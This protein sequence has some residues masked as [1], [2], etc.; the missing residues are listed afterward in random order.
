[1]AT[2]AAAVAHD[3]GGPPV[4]AGFRLAEGRTVLMAM[5]ETTVH[6]DDGA[7]PREDDVRTAGEQSVFRA[8]HR[9]AVTETVEHRSENELG[10][11][12]APADAGHDLRALFRGEDVGH[13]KKV[14]SVQ[15]SVFSKSWKRAGEAASRMGSGFS[16]ALPGDRERFEHR[17]S[18]L[19]HRT[20]KWMNECRERDARAPSGLRL[21]FLSTLN[22]P[23]STVRSPF[24]VEVFPGTFVALEAR[25]FVELVR[26]IVFVVFSDEFDLSDFVVRSTLGRTEDGEEAPV[27]G[28]DGLFQAGLQVAVPAVRVGG[29]DEVIDEA[30]KV[31]AVAGA[32]QLFRGFRF[33]PSEME[34]LAAGSVRFAAFA[35]TQ[36]QFSWPWWSCAR[37]VHESECGE[38]KG[39][40]PVF[41]FD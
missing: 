7:Q 11:R 21:F 28:V 27:G 15:F 13:W 25:A 5:P 26:L 9:E 20:L 31:G 23:L 4:A 1:M 10:P 38:E 37:F 12:V 41:T 16:T 22:H 33:R 18:N 17:T 36:R 40:L 14:A 32:H 8:V 19:Q 35:R 39:G 24:A 3:L 2:I 6:E 34:W 30:E 29:G